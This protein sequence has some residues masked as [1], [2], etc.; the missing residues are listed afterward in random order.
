MKGLEEIKLWFAATENLYGSKGSQNGD[1]W[2]N[3]L[4]LDQELGLAEYQHFW[5]NPHAKDIPLPQDLKKLLV[6]LA[7]PHGKSILKAYRIQKG[8]EK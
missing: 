1:G 7:G 3:C 8:L 6:M 4:K 2:S 5:V